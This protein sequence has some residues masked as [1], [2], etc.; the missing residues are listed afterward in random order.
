MHYYLGKS[1][2]YEPN[3][4]PR[5]SQRHANMQIHHQ[6]TCQ[7]ILVPPSSPNQALGFFRTRPDVS[8]LTLSA[9][10]AGSSLGFFL[11]TLAARS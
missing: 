11:T 2:E 9:A 7:C 8:V 3:V 1:Y 4:C 10:C 5:T 6:V